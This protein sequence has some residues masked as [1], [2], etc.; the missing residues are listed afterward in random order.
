MDTPQLVGSVNTGPRTAHC[1]LS[2]VFEVQKDNNETFLHLF[3]S[4]PSNKTVSNS[5]P[6]D[7]AHRKQQGVCPPF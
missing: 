5:F 2:A 1:V 6:A 7:E 4:L 3:I